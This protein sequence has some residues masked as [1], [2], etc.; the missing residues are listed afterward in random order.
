MQYIA[1]EHS[2]VQYSA[3][4]QSILQHITVNYS[5]V[6]SKNKYYSM[7][8]RPLKISKTQIAIIVHGLALSCFSTEVLRGEIFPFDSVQLK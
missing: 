6:N 2:A 4:P 3:L 8:D 1:V 7:T 5:I